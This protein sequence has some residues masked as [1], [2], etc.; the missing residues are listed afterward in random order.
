MPTESG[1]VMFTIKPVEQVFYLFKKK[2]TRELKK[3]E[4]KMH[5]INSIFQN[6]IDKGC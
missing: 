5:L 2:Q 3:T 4:K 6:H 1:R